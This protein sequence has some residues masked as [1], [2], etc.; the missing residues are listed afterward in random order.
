MCAHPY[1]LVLRSGAVAQGVDN[2]GKDLL[3]TA[4]GVIQLDLDLQLCTDLVREA[5]G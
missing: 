2:M 1:F 5:G 3:Y 4:P